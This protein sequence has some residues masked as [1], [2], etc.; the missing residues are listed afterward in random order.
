MERKINPALE[1]K[2]IAQLAAHFPYQ[3]KD[4]KGR[5]VVGVSRETLATHL[6]SGRLQLEQVEFLGR[7]FY[8]VPLEDQKADM[9]TWKLGKKYKAKRVGRPSN[10]ERLGLK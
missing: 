1:L 6:R 8:Y 3:K 2:T 4:E 10:A 7:I 5:T 9:R